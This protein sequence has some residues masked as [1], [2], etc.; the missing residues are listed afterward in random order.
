MRF[1]KNSNLYI[2][3][4]IIVVVVIT[5]A[6]LAFTSVTLKE[7]QNENAA[8]EK[9]RQILASI[10]MSPPE[11]SISAV[12]ASTI[13]SQFIVNSAG[14]QVAGDAFYVDVAAQV[15][16]PADERELP[17][18]VATLPD[19]HTKYI[20]PVY[21][22]GLWGPIW[23][24]ISLDHDRSTIYGAYFAHQGETPGLGAEITK[25]QFTDQFES[26]SLFHDGAF[27]PVQVLKKGQKPDG[28]ADFVDAVSGGTI[29][30]RGVASMLDNSLAPYS[31]FLTHS[32]DLYDG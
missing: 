13:T 16:L 1:N 11:D 7:R 31:Y 23:G 18:F 25:P 4:Y 12:F 24:Y 19:G 6:A 5:G 22:A 8:V 17:V 3:I 29:T 2:I 15:S 26:K 21:G 32:E 20:L 27:T 9:M 28:D 14:E 30:S 10:R